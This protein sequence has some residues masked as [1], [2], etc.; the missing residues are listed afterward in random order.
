MGRNTGKR[1][2]RW[3][4][5]Q[6]KPSLNEEQKRILLKSLRFDQIDARFEHIV[7]AHAK[8]C[9]WLLES[10]E[11][12]DWL[13]PSKLGE[14]H[15]FL[16]IKA[17]PGAGK[18]TL[19]KFALAQAKK[20]MKDNVVI[21]FF[22]NARGD[23][24]EKS[25]IGMY[26]SLLLQLLE[27]CPEYQHALSSLGLVVPS[28]GPQRWSLES[29]KDLF[30]KAVE[31]LGKSSLVCFIDALDECDEDQI[32]DMVSFFAHIGELATLAHVGFKVCFSSRYYPHI[33]LPKGLGL[34]LKQQQGHGQDITYFLDSELRIGR[35]QLADKIRKSVQ[36]KASGIFLW[37]FMVVKIL[38]KVYDDGRTHAL[39]KTL[40]EL[41][42]DL[43]ALFHNILTRDNDKQD[44]LLLCIQWVLFARY[45]LR[46]Q[47]LYFAILS[48]VEPEALS[49]CNPNDITET[50]I[51][52]YV[53]SSSKGLAEITRTKHPTVQ[54][55]H[56]SVRD[57][58]LKQ[59]GLK[60]IWPDLE[61]NFQGESH[62][63]L[64]RC[65]LN[66]ISM[67]I[68]YQLNI[69][70]TLPK[71]SSPEASIL[72]QVADEMFPFL[73]YAVRN[74]LRHADDAEGFDVKQM[75]FLEEFPLGDW[76]QLDN[77]FERHEVRW[78]SSNAR[79][80]Y[81]L[82]EH[83]MGN[84]IKAHPCKRSCFK[85]GIERYGAPIFAALA[86]G[87]DEALRAF[88]KAQ[89][90][91]QP[92]KSLHKV[93]EQYWENKN[94]RPHYG[95]QFKFKPWR[96]VLF[97]LLEKGDAA[98]IAAFLTLSDDV[99]VNLTDGNDRT[100]LSRAAEDGHA[101]VAKLLLDNGADVNARSTLD[102]TSLLYA[103]SE[104]HETL[105][106][107]LLENGA[108]ID[109]KDM[110]GKTP[111]SQAANN[112]HEAVIQLLLAKGANIDFLKDGIR[113]T[114][115]LR[116]AS[117]G[118]ETL[119]KLLLEK[120]ASTDAMDMDGT[121]PLC[122]AA[123]FGHENVVKLLLEKGASIDAKDMG[124]RTPLSQAANYGHKAV[125]RLLLAKGATIDL[126]DGIGRTPLLRAADNGHEAVVQLL[127]AKGATID[128]R[129][130]IGSTP[131]LRAAA[132]GNEN[133]VKLLLERGASIDAI[134]M[135]GRTPLCQAA[136]HGHDN[137]VKLLL[138]NGADVN[139]ID[140]RGHTALE[141]AAT[142]GHE[143]V[144]ELLREKGASI[145]LEDK[146]GATPLQA[147][148]IH[149]PT[150][151]MLLDH[152][153]MSDNGETSLEETS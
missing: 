36:E 96:G 20:I 71:A 148:P 124:S 119:V 94:K 54:F 111:L 139:L 49:R 131:L 83:D 137:V 127:L 13:D 9:K 66:Y 107:L 45:P 144:A 63:R 73:E 50:A 116:A 90:E 64:K 17:K 15:G 74:I 65:C 5:P 86:T 143:Y 11:F 48:G 103:A 152:G 149:L 26:R 1:D 85:V 51:K 110:E 34:D 30:Q 33:T 58:L 14:H 125:V 123:I 35:G 106:E 16:W 23:D 92:S 19:M 129:D 76:I 95:R 4:P 142:N 84:L 108:S 21:S 40:Q 97:H 18:S 151:M 31:G 69:G 8:T 29:L 88:L 145:D 113:S 136:L 93:V 78:H 28:D 67:G 25:T 46:P 60:E 70:P 37:V 55:I 80:L 7:L 3:N 47:Q 100:P 53:I 120:G 43:H 109:A 39:E 112:G 56:E 140:S 133:L 77:L 138:E 135:E 114:S 6:A 132:K 52:R 118:N 27:K 68:C 32:R 117:N 146:A 153:N 61:R 126:K 150:F 102:R 128:L 105:V 82:A 104:G 134:D 98:I 130:R 122:Q 75:S 2:C 81:I 99:D 44:H 72:R 147:A 101:V 24:L 79:L 38:N 57:F 141:H 42:R 91:N 62:D 87:S 22:F 59:N 121:T 115:L 89:I 12:R 10:S 41:P